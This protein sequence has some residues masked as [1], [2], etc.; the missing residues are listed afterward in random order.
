MC[1]R[2]TNTTDGAAFSTASARKL[3]CLELGR[4]EAADSRGRRAADNSVKYSEGLYVASFSF[5]FF[6]TAYSPHAL[7][8]P[9]EK[10][11]LAPI[12]CLSFFDFSSLLALAAPDALPNH[13]RLNPPLVLTKGLAVTE[14][15][16]LGHER[17][18][19]LAI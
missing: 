16:S 17:S 19:A 11:C 8:A 3:N 6:E 2:S 7:R 1:L 5:N 9:A 10:R 12:L 4:S 15:H 18:L 13:V 14:D